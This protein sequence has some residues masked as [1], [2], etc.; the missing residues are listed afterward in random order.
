MGGFLHGNLLETKQNWKKFSL[1]TP[2][3]WIGGQSSGHSSR[4]K[5]LLIFEKPVSGHK[6]S[7]TPRFPTHTPITPA[8]QK[9]CQ[10]VP[11]QHLKHIRT[12][13]L[14][15]MKTW[16]LRESRAPSAARTA[17]CFTP[18]NLDPMAQ[19]PID[20]QR[21]VSLVEANWLCLSQFPRRHSGVPQLICCTTPLLHIK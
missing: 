11:Q 12:K 15:S 20:R 6:T 4:W 19:F 1:A 8:S 14:L 5:L 13:L 16:E 7:T 10:F 21:P 17:E 3:K 2:V 9:T 18:W